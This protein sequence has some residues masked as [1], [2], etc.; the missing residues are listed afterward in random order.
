[1]GYLN[2]SLTFNTLFFILAKEKLYCTC[3]KPEDDSLEWIKCDNGLGC[4]IGWYH[5]TCVGI[6]KLTAKIIKSEF[7]K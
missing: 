3:R 1:L 6:P 7:P 4:K 2:Y 5:V